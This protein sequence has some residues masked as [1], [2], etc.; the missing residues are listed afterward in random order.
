MDLDL[1]IL[2]SLILVALFVWMFNLDNYTKMIFGRLA[3]TKYLFIT[4]LAIF[5][6][7]VFIQ[8]E[9]KV[10]QILKFCALSFTTVIA[11]FFIITLNIS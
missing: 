7:M 6:A 5:M 1:I 9:D 3:D 11:I 10:I 8:S 4:V 2:P